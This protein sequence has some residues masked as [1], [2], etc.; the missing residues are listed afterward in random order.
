MSKNVLRCDSLQFSLH[1]LQISLSLCIC[2]YSDICNMKTGMPKKRFYLT[3]HSAY[4]IL[5]YHYMARE[6]SHGT[7]KPAA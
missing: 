6:V 5:K 1:N 3:P 2:E 7:Q 4:I